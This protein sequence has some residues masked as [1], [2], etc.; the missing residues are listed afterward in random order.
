M[1]GELVTMTSD[2]YRHSLESFVRTRRFT[3]DWNAR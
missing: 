2:D 3:A 1:A